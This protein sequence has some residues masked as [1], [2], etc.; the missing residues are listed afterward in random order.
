[1]TAK[2]KKPAAKRKPK[3]RAPELERALAAVQA[4]TRTFETNVNDMRL[5]NAELL[6]RV[7]RL[8]EYVNDTRSPQALYE[9]GDLDGLLP[10]T[11]ADFV[12]ASGGSVSVTFAVTE[13]CRAERLILPTSGL[14][15]E[16]MR[17]GTRSLF[18]GFGGGVSLRSGL[19]WKL[20]DPARSLMPG[21]GA[22]LQLRNPTGGAITF[23][24]A[25]IWAR[26]ASERE[27]S[28]PFGVGS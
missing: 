15:F 19:N 11:C 21:I 2:K 17:I 10:V 1:M 16:G 6:E 4:I 23:L 27:Y 5:S 7:Q 3:A 14:L 28:S 9:P 22:S 12:V 8:R 24:G 26:P 13:G 25:A 18:V 20:P